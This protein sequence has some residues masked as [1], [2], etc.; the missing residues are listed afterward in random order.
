ML[1][2]TLFG[3]CFDKLDLFLRCWI[4]LACF[5]QGDALLVRVGM[6]CGA[7]YVPDSSGRLCKLYRTVGGATERVRCLAGLESTE[8]V[9]LLVDVTDMG[10]DM[11]ACYIWAVVVL[12]AWIFKYP[13]PNHRDDNCHTNAVCIVGHVRHARWHRWSPCRVASHKLFL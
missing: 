6:H 7:T 9:P 10:P 4:C 3:M 8:E 13:D 5:A 1:F 2:R 11:L 12:G